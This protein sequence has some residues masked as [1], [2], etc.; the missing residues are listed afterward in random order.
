M[1]EEVEVAAEAERQAQ[2]RRLQVEVR[3]VPSHRQQERSP[4]PPAETHLVATGYQASSPEYPY[5]LPR[6]LSPWNVS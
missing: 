6:R 4:V 5:H 2:D 3:V 1:E